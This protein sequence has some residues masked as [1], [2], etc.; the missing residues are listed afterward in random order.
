[1]QLLGVSPDPESLS[2]ETVSRLSDSVE[3]FARSTTASATC[4]AC[5]TPS[6][7]V[8]SIYARRP[9]DLP[10]QGLAV[11][12][13]LRVR[14]F[15]CDLVSCAKRIFTERLSG[16]LAPYARKTERF[17]DAIRALGAVAGGEQGHA[18]AC[19]LA[20]PCSADTVLRQLRASPLQ[21]A[22]TPRALGVDD[23]AIRKGQS[24]ATILVDLERGRVV[25]LLADRAP[26]TL[27]AWLRAHPGV[28]IVSRD[29]AAGYAKGARDG[30]PGAIQ[31]ADRWHLLR[32]LVEAVERVVARHHAA[33]TRA[34]RLSATKGAADP[35]PLAP[36][37]RAVRLRR[38]RAARRLARYERARELYAA[39]HTLSSIERQ[40]GISRGTV[41]AY[42]RGECPTGA[43]PLRGSSAEP[44]RARLEAL[45]E[46]GV[47]DGLELYR[48]VC[49]EGFEGSART[50][51][52]FVRPWRGAARSERGA[53]TPAAARAASSREMAWWFVPKRRALSSG[54][55]EQKA[56]VL[57]SVPELGPVEECARQF[58]E[59]LMKRSALSLDE[60]LDETRRSCPPL[61]S[62]MEG[63]ERDREAVGN[64]IALEWSNGATE[65]HVNRLKAL[66]RQMYGR[67]KLD[68]LRIRLLSV[69]R[70]VEAS[71]K[72]EE[73][74]Q[75]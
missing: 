21:D 74:P 61:S 57:A 26:D 62:F 43:R 75:N 66:K 1:M 14:R 32:N 53:P 58:W 12:L 13:R 44:W 35:I 16:V 39:G 45:W 54:E 70:K 63:I 60:W 37:T 19:A 55:L 71:S 5:A 52:R 73:E 33:I 68:L 56:L 17:L 41:R 42:V 50:V 8:H 9:A 65:G 29:R 38:E 10:I 6:S 18:A 69:P 59:M 3:I 49:A 30:A 51:Q 22:P 7:R 48:A 15:F 20:M 36:E 24:Y 67:A 2:F 28:E 72:S 31:V 47:R 34:A 40:M 4:P 46:Q 25:D 11:R 27:A 23:W 64:A